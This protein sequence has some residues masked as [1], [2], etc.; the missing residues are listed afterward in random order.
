MLEQF[1]SRAAPRLRSRPLGARLDSFVE[2][3]S[4]LGYRP[5]TC[6]SYVV[7]AADLGRWMADHGVLIKELDESVI[8]AYVEQR[9]AQPDRRRAAAAHLLAHLRA[10]GVAPPRPVL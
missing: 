9:R 3:L 4:G 5:R 6:R 8:D 1:F 2:R 7:L 10:E